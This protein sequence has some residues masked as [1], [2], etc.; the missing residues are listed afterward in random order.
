MHMRSIKMRIATLATYLLS[1]FNVVALLHFRKVLL[2]A[3][4]VVP[5]LYRY[6]WILAGLA[7]S[8][9]VHIDMGWARSVVHFI[10]YCRVT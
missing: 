2:L 8:F 5:I 6:I 9:K 7:R 10:L 1:D 3:L 4:A